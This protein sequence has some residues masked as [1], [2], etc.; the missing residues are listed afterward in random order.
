MS[1][2]FQKF[3]PV[4]NAPTLRI[5]SKGAAAINKGAAAALQ[6]ELFPH[7][8]WLTFYYDA[9][10]KVLAFTFSK[11]ESKEG[12]KIS[13]A[14]QFNLGPLFR[15][16]NIKIPGRGTSITADVEWDKTEEKYIVYYPE[17]KKSNPEKKPKNPDTPISHGPCD[18]CAAKATW[19]RHTQFAGDHFFCD[20]CAQKEKEKS[21]D[22]S[23]ENLNPCR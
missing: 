15:H 1:F 8:G 9:K 16:F 11:G 19:V 22:D 7:G 2:N 18:D 20:D 17:K 12:I 23:W 3:N 10:A 14:G 4:G 13:Q 21:P 6:L 5:S